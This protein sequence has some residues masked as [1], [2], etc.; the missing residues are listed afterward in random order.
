MKA[1]SLINWG[2]AGSAHVCGET[3]EPRSPPIAVSGDQK[4]LFAGRI[5]GSGLRG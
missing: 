1:Q 3:A 4:A 2:K 5:G